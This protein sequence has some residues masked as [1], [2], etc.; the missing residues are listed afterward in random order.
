MRRPAALFRLDVGLP[1]LMFGGFAG[2]GPQAS[3]LAS[4]AGDAPV[5]LAMSYRRL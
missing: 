3:R 1:G 5:S 4:L 2:D